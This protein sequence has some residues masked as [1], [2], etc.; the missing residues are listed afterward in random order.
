MSAVPS[1]RPAAVWALMAL[2][3]LQGICGIAGGVALVAAPDGRIMKMPV[4]QLDGSPF[5]SYLIPGL[6]LLIVLGILPLDVLAGL[7]L[8]PKVAWY[9]SLVVGCG[10]VL[11]IVVQVLYIPFSALQTI[12]GAVG[13]LI[14]TVTLLPS[15]RDYCGVTLRR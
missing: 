6:I 10:L 2:L 14:A 4:A 9:G 1:S 8:Q 5:S 12:F 3:L 11:W 13:L 15:V 7:W